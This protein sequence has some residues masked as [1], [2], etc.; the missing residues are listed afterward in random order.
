LASSPTAEPERAPGASDR[1][2]DAHDALRVL[3]ALL[4]GVP[5][6][7][8]AALVHA[9]VRPGPVTPVAGPAPWLLGVS[10]VR[11]RVLPVGDLRRLVG[12]PIGA[13]ADAG[14]GDAASAGAGPSGARWWVVVDDG[15]RAAA[16]DGLRVCRVVA[17]VP[18]DVATVGEATGLPAGGVVRLEGDSSRGSD[19]L[20]PAATLLDVA[21]LL[22]LVHDSPADGDRPWGAPP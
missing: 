16:F 7:L 2:D 18:G 13:A 9:V 1:G 22:D 8:D 4:G 12:T 11:G 6:A 5:V 20:P 19:A 3:V 10:A 21:A 14:P 15:R 17:G